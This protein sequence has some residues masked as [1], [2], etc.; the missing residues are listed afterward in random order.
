MVNKVN[1]VRLGQLASAYVIEG[2]CIK[3][4]GF[5]PRV[6][7]NE[8]IG[9]MVANYENIVIQE[10]GKIEIYCDENFFNSFIDYINTTIETDF[11]SKQLNQLYAKG[12]LE[13]FV[14]YSNKKTREQAYRESLVEAYIERFIKSMI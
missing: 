3:A 4:R 10:N 12:D 7:S 2:V 9:R 5:D 14:K 6:I 13:I 8:E 11:G 1:S